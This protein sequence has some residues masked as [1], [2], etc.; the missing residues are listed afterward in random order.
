MDKRQT[1]ENFRKRLAQL[2]A[3]SGLSQTAF[4]RAIQID[5]SALS[6]LTSGL[7]PRLP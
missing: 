5:R 1:A 4:A 3:Q 2:Q 7:N 6:Q